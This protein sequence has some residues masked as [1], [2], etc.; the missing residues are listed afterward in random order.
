MTLK[1][2]KTKWAT[3]RIE[4][5]PAV[6]ANAQGQPEVTIQME[7]HE[8]PFGDLI[9]AYVDHVRTP[10]WRRAPGWSLLERL[11]REELNKVGRLAWHW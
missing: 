1:E 2:W 11:M 8:A 3:G 7:R 6:I 9:K 4:D 5:V 10:W